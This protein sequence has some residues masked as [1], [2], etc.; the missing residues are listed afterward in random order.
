MIS[1]RFTAGAAVARLLGFVSLTAFAIAVADAAPSGGPY[2]PIRQHYEIP[3]GAPHV[4]Y[5]A[6]DARAESSG[7]T[8]AEPTT[9]ANAL[10]RAT[11]GDVVVLRGG[12][13]RTGSLQLNQGITIQPYADEQPVLKGT[14]VATEWVAQRN[15]LWRTSW[16][17]LF[18]AQAA[19]WWHR[20]SEGAKTPPHRFN[21]DMVFVDGRP[22][23]S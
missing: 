7:A 9:L 8:L 2:G 12:T 1:P 22:L 23:R 10:T 3:A 11:T 6:S 16:K 19:D 21:N 14:E 17:K 15:G 20:G 18:P 13:Y 4:I 5:V